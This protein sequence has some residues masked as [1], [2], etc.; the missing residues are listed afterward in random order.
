MFAPDQYALL[1][2]GDGRKLERFGSWVLDRPAPAAGKTRR[3]APDRWHRAHARFTRPRSGTAGTWRDRVPIPDSWPVAW[4]HGISF[5]LHRNAHGHVG[6]FPEQAACWD[7]IGDVVRRASMPVNVLN[8][9]AYTGGST[10]AAAQAGARVAHIDA[11]RNM[12]ARARS[13]AARSN[14]EQAPVRWIAEDARRF[15]AREERRGRTYHGIILDPPSYGHGPRGQ[16][17]H[18]EEDLPE[19][20]RSCW[21]CTRNDPLFFLVT[22]HRQGWTPAELREMVFEHARLPYDSRWEA[23][24]LSIATP[25]GRSLDSGLY[26][27]WTCL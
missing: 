4:R 7:W 24:H 14:L 15:V 1:D 9:F 26:A 18:L 12:V 20:L 22:C 2:F 11:A 8:L 10:L 27:R 6:L 23:G 19:L 3:H 16:A 25:D 21:R 13:N 17:W 5:Q